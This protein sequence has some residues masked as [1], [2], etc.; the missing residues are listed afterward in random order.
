MCWYY[1]ETTGP[2]GPFTEAALAH[3][4]SCSLCGGWFPPDQTLSIGG[5]L[6]CAAC[7]P[8]RVQQLKEGLAAGQ[9]AP[10]LAHLLQIA[11]AQRGL[12]WTIFLALSLYAFV[13]VARAS[14]NAA[15]AIAVIA[16]VLALFFLLPF[17]LVYVYRLAAALNLGDPMLWVL[18]VAFCSWIGGLLLL[19]LSWRA[20][21]TLR[22]AGFRVGLLGADPTDIEDAL[23]L[24]R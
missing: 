2:K 12:I 1:A 15:L 10:P 4:R 20:T 24:G 3:A 13:A 19:L 8:L 22:A 9:A 7:K 23:A 6:V 16:A 21:R 18:G 5:L 17:Q 14:G 11:K